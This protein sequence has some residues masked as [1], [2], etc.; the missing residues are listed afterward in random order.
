MKY[1]KGFRSLIAWQ[2][3]KEL[4]LYIYQATKDFPKEEK[5]GITSQLRRAASSVMAN[6]AEG[7]DR[8]T[9]GDSKHFLVIAR[10]SLVEVDNFW[11]LS[12][13]L[14]Y[15]NED[16]FLKGLELINKTG[17]LINRLHDAQVRNT[18]KK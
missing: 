12:R 15:L 4:T 2:K 13:D 8:H 5:Y 14:K 18:Q 7:N 3:A 1:E 16:I 17:Y 9:K 10:G 6:T 11:E